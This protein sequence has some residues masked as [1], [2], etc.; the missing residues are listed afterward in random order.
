MDLLTPEAH[1]GAYEWAA[2]LL[3]HFALGGYATACLAFVFQWAFPAPYRP[4]GQFALG[5]LLAVLAA[6]YGAGWEGLVQGY[7]AGLADAA[8]DTVA[9]T[10]GGV[11]AWAAWH[12]RARLIGAALGIVTAIAALGIRKRTKRH[13]FEDF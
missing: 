12:R 11:A 3:A 9:V 4:H 7:G 13:E 2:V 5:T 10:C 8:V 1:A 6:L